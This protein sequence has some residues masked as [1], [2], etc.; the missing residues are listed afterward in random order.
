LPDEFIASDFAP[1]AVMLRGGRHVTLR[2][3]R[4]GDEAPLQAALH[5]LSGESRYMRFM[6]AVNELSPSM[7]K[8]AVQPVAG[9]D[10]AL[11]ALADPADPGAEGNIVGGARY[12]A[13][14][15]LQ[16]CEFGIALDD[17]WRGTGLASRLMQELIRSARARAWTEG[18][19]RLHPREQYADAQS[20][21][22]TGFR[23][24]REQRGAWRGARVAGPARLAGRRDAGSLSRTR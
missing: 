16:T 9:R 14:L 2:S 13:D 10:L 12:I 20:R 8:S 15:A 1:V 7:L 24:H 3:I 18:H 11:V 4:P 22:A 21:Q 17:D 19:G 6:S 5:R 23:S